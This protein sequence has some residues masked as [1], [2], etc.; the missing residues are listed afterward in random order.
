MLA[1]AVGVGVTGGL[2]GVVDGLAVVGVGV[3][4]GRVLVG[5]EAGVEAFG[6]GVRVTEGF[7]LP[8]EEG[9]PVGITPVRGASGSGATIHSAPM[10]NATAA[11]KAPHAHHRRWRGA[12]CRLISA[13]LPSCC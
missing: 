6:E 1:V 4:L 13:R 9:V 7:G 11:P 2:G 5:C 8:D 3:G 12:A 10:R